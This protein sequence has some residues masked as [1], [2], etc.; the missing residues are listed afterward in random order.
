[1]HVIVAIAVLGGLLGLANLLMPRSLM[2]FGERWTLK[3][4]D[5][6]EPSDAYVLYVRVFGVIVLL[7]TAAICVGVAVAEHD[8]AREAEL[9]EL[10]D[11]NLYPGDGVA[12]VG[13]P[14]IETSGE[15]TGRQVVLSPTR[16]AI[17]GRDDLGDLAGVSAFDDG[18][19]LVGMGYS[20]C[21]FSH[22]IVTR[23]GD[24]TVVG[25]VVELPE[26]PDLPGITPPDATPSPVDTLRDIQFCSR[27]FST[28]DAT[29]GLTV[30]RVPGDG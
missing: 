21:D 14:R 26:L 3:D 16:T 5:R 23:D 30:F 6:A 15:P 10:W 19:L 8:R 22:L 1:M 24:R 28:H 17:V 9:E 2:L 29:I 12:V 13:E 20:T 27:R 11:V 18:D 7:A 4:G 25:I